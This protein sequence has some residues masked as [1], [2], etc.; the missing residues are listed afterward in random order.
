MA[1][2]EDFEKIEMRLGK[3]VEMADVLGAIL[4]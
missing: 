1:T 3:I 2:I 4:Q